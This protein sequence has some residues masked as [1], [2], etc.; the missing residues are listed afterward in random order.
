[1]II[2]VRSLEEIIAVITV[3]AIIARIATEHII[4]SVTTQCVVASITA[5]IIGSR[6][7]LDDVI[8]AACV[9]HLI[10]VGEGDVAEIKSVVLAIAQD[11]YAI[12][13]DLIDPVMSREIGDAEMSSPSVLKYVLTRGVR[14][15]IVDEVFASLD[16]VGVVSGAA[17]ELVSA[18][19]AL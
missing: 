2:S 11:L 17:E 16:A 3:E 12:C 18:S 5:N 6:V 19:A 15:L 4:A 14:D 1:M 7:T 13:V 10:W 9:D 8:T